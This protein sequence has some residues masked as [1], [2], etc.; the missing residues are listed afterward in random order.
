MHV[1]DEIYDGGASAPR[2]KTEGQ[3]STAAKP[4]SITRPAAARQ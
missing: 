1:E 2:G 4:V 3:V